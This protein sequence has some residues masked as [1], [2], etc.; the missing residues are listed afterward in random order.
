MQHP[1]L[2][3][4]TLGCR[5]DGCVSL[6][7]AYK[8]AWAARTEAERRVGRRAEQKRRWDRE[9]RSYRVCRGPRPDLSTPAS[10]M[11]F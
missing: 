10:E 9:N 1:G 7:N 2:R 4:Y 6:R 8:R 11:P 5:C 3:A